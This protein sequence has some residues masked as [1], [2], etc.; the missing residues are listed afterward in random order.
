VYTVKVEATAVEADGT[1]RVA[2]EVAKAEVGATASDL[3]PS[4]RK[5]AEL[6]L[7]L[8]RGKR[9]T[10]SIDSRGVVSPVVFDPGG[11]YAPDVPLLLQ[12]MLQ[13][14]IVAVPEEE[15]G[16]GGKWTVRRS[17]V[18]RS[19]RGEEV[20]T[21]EVTKLEGSRVEMTMKTEWNAPQQK[22]PGTATTLGRAQ[23]VLLAESEGTGAGTWDLT[24]LVPVSFEAENTRKTS[25]SGPTANGYGR[26]I[27]SVVV[28]VE[29]MTPK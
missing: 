23:K 28:T 24:S 10:Y 8:A 7:G 22:I 2:F 3:S 25:I 17:T 4:M 20:S 15:V 21:I 19:I 26:A 13:R 29:S 1:V 18:A 27:E 9:G 6:W 12:G 11:L 5:A 14:T 16:Q